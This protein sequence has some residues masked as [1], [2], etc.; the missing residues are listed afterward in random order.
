[1]TRCEAEWLNSHD[2]CGEPIPERDPFWPRDV[3]GELILERPNSLP[4]TLPQ[5]SSE[6]P[7]ERPIVRTR[8]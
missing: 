1:M 8:P 3:M 4:T 7:P 2:L 5:K 6:M